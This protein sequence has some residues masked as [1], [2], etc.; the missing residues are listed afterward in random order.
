MNVYSL[1]SEPGLQPSASREERHGR[2]LAAQLMLLHLFLPFHVADF[3]GPLLR[4]GMM[5]RAANTH[6]VRI[7]EELVTREGA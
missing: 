7:Q 1:V 3:A 5:L 2:E 4:L 6:A